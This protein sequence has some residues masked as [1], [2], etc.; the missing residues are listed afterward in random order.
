MK[1]HTLDSI[2]ATQAGVAQQAALMRLQLYLVLRTH[3]LLRTVLSECREALEATELTAAREPGTWDGLA[4]HTAIES[5]T[6]IWTQRFGEWRSIFEHLRSAAAALPIGTLAVLHRA[7]FAG[8]AEQ[9]SR[10]QLSEAGTVPVFEPQLQAL[11]DA[12]ATRVWG[13]GLTL[14]QRI[15]RLEHEG[16][17]GIRQVLYQGIAEGDSAWRMARKLEPFLGAGGGCPRWARS[18]LYRLTKTDI[19]EGDRTGLYSGDECD[20]QGIAY[21]ALRLARNEIQIAHHLASDAMLEAIPWLEQEQIHLSPAHPKP[22]ICDDLVNGG[23]EGDGVYPKG[24]VLLPAHV[25]CLCYKTAVLPDS[26]EFA[27]RLRGWLRGET[28]WPAMDE[29]AA[30]LGVGAGDLTNS[31]LIT[32]LAVGLA[33]QLVVWLWGDQSAMDAAAANDVLAGEQLV[34]S[35]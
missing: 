15:W 7:A 22:D 5:V 34:F 26:A 12:A 18:R 31:G 21:K 30:W 1:A 20:G 2:T 8:L 27:G 3:E 32:G 16:L 23:A 11:L 14:S 9:R 24:S 4:A 25:Q 29:Y 17:D 35:W 10:G 28:S 19:A 6:R 13:D 33:S